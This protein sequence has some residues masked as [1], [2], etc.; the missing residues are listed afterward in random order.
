MVTVHLASALY[1]GKSLYT[2]LCERNFRLLPFAL[3]TSCGLIS[4][5]I[6]I[7]ELSFMIKV[8]M[9]PQNCCL[10]IAEFGTDLNCDR[11]DRC[12]LKGRLEWKMIHYT[13]DCTTDYT[14]LHCTRRLT[15]QLQNF[16]PF[17]TFN[18]IVT[19]HSQC[20]SLD[21][22]LETRYSNVFIALIGIFF[23]YVLQ[24]LYD[25]Q[26]YFILHHEM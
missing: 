21:L 7:T 20:P 11:W 22:T 24:L 13:A 8:L 6:I 5:D 26:S 25:F 2:F 14:A 1:H 18:Y 15:S 16:Q 19:S 17:L 4:S 23:N 9:K 3:E 10:F 12:G